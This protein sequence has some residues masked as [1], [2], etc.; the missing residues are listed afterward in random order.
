[1]HG[2]I[3]DVKVDPGREEEARSMTREMIVP[4]A[5]AHPGFVAGY[6]LRALDGDVIRSVHLYE[7]EDNARTAAEAIRAQG[8]P[9]GAPVALHSISTYEVLAQA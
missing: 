2:V 1:M 6:W 3:I 4:K 5:R 7:S 9:P 8:P